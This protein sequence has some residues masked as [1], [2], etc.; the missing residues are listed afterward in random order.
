VPYN[1]Q[2][3]WS[4]WDLGDTQDIALDPVGDSWREPPEPQPMPAFDGHISPSVFKSDAGHTESGIKWIPEKRELRLFIARGIVGQFI[5]KDGLREIVGRE[6]SNRGE[7]RAVS[8]V[9]NQCDISA[10]CEG[11]MNLR[12][13]LALWGFKRDNSFSGHGLCFAKD[14]TVKQEAPPTVA[15]KPPQPKTAEEWAQRYKDEG[16]T[17]LPVSLQRD[18]E[19]E[20]RLKLD[21][22]N[23]K[24]HQRDELQKR[25]ADL[26]AQAQ[27]EK[28]KP[29]PQ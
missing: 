28:E 3:E 11:S 4:I 15:P 24:Y 20:R 1:A 10:N 21:E 29:C 12:S 18:L 7:I 23:D 13:N 14:L 8:L 5:T 22:A 9:F 27:Q 16:L 2:G 17:V 25:I 19:H 26:K 6:T